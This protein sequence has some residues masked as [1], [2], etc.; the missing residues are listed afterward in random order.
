MLVIP[1]PTV[2]LIISYSLGQGRQTAPASVSGTALGDIVAMSASLLGAGVLLATSSTLFLLLKSLGAVYL[3]LLG[4]S[5]WRSTPV[6]IQDVQVLEKKTPNSRIFIS[7]F[8]ITALNPKSIIFFTA[9][10][11]QFVRPH[12]GDVFLQFTILEVTFVGLATINSIIW[13]YVADGMR[14][15]FKNPASMR[16]AGKIGGSIMIVTG[17]LTAFSQQLL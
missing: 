16:L 11:P 12:Q 5:M 17:L 9:F 2:M 10:V 6:T 13:A 4:V 3:I 1:G 8:V 15:K 14:R 7:A